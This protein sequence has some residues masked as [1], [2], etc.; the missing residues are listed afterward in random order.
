MCDYY[1][2]RIINSDWPATVKQSA[3]AWLIHNNEQV[4][5]YD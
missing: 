5:T 3:L 4:F 2:D 1:A